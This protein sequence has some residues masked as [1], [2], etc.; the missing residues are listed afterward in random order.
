[1]VQ[2]TTVGDLAA[3]IGA[4]AAMLGVLLG[5]VVTHLVEQHR[6]LGSGRAEPRWIDRSSAAYLEV[7]LAARDRARDVDEVRAGRK[8]HEDLS[9]TW[10]LDSAVAR[11]RAY[12]PD[13]VCDPLDKLAAASREVTEAQTGCASGSLSQRH[14]ALLGALERVEDAVREHL[15]SER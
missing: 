8:P 12:A 7:V 3:A 5:A 9:L 14:Q 4:G 1:M 13:T 15:G 2:T 6:H 10:A 11:A